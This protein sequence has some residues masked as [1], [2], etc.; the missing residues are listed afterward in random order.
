[1]VG[2]FHGIRTSRPAATCFIC[3][4]VDQA[5]KHAMN[6]AVHSADLGAC[7]C[8]AHIAGRLSR[9]AATLVSVDKCP[10]AATISLVGRKLCRLSDVI[11]ANVRQRLANAADS[12]K[13]AR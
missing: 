10:H 13:A 11:W 3:F 9:G 7:R 12:V 8:E 5:P 4:T 2:T 6:D 1:M